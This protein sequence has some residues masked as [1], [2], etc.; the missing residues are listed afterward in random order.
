MRGK[1]NEKDEDG[2]QFLNIMRFIMHHK[3]MLVKREDSEEK[4]DSFERELN[5]AVTILNNR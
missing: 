4:D 5:R 1:R 3:H 2:D